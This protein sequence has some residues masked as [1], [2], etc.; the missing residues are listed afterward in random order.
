MPS[1]ADGISRSQ[2]SPPPP[3]PPPSPFLYPNLSP[4]D[5][6]PTFAIT[7]STLEFLSDS[8]GSLGLLLVPKSSY[9]FLVATWCTSKVLPHCFPLTLEPIVLVGW[10]SGQSFYDSEG[11]GAAQKC[12]HAL[13]LYLWNS[14]SYNIS[15][16][17]LGIQFLNFFRVPQ[18]LPDFLWSISISKDCLGFWTRG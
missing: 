12:C 7:C 6:L 3:P 18:G 14:W 16:G 13:F 5:F 8:Q 17:L 15:S 1:E 9:G 2:Y 4:I 11:R 10:N